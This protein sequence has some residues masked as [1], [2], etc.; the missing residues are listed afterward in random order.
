MQAGPTRVELV[1]ETLALAWPDGEESYLEA[2][3]LRERSPSAEQQ[4]ET[5]LFGSVS[6]GI[7][8]GDYSSVLI[9]R[10]EIVGNYA[11]RIQFSDGHSTGIY[12]WD[13]LRR[14]A[15]ESDV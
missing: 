1:G 4:G 7:S 14:I 12:S 5:D 11:L 6:G 15:G 8:G 9:R 10:F 13:Y 3:F 2:P